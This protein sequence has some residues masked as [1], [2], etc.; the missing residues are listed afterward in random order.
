[1]YSRA[2]NLDASGNLREAAKIAH[3]E[4]RRYEKS[5]PAPWYW[6]FRLLEAEALLGQG[7]VKEANSLLSKP[8]PANL[9]SN[10]IEVRRQYDRAAALYGSGHPH[11]ALSTLEQIR[12]SAT[13]PELQARIDMLSGGLLGFFRKLDE[14][15]LLLNRA[16][17]EATRA[18]TPYWKVGTF[19]N[20]SSCRKWAFRYSEAVEFGLQAAGIAEQ[21]GYRRLGASAHTN[22]GSYYRIL[23]DYDRAL[24]EQRKGIADLAAMGDRNALMIAYGEFGLLYEA[25]QEYRQAIEQ[26]QHAYD[27]ALAMGSNADAARHAVNLS[28]TYIEL[29][30]SE[31]SD[32]S[33]KAEEWN[34]KS[35]QLAGP[36]TASGP[37]QTFNEA[38]IAWNSGRYE[39]GN[40]LSG[41]LLHLNGVPP[42]LLWDVHYY[43][44]RAAASRKQYTD[45]KREYSAAVG[46]VDKARS[47]LSGPTQRITFLSRLIAIHR[48]YIALEVEQGHNLEAIRLAEASRVRVLAERVGGAAQAQSLDASRLTRLATNAKISLISFWLAPQRSYAWLITSA[49]IERF[50]L[51]GIEEIEPVV[52][53]YRDV[54]EHP[55]RDPIATHE[56]NG[57][58]LWD[59]LLA[60]IAPKIPKGSRVIVIPDGPL[61]R[62]NLETLPVPSSPP[63]Y[64]MEDVELAV[65]P[66]LSIAASQPATSDGSGLLAIGAADYAGTDY[67]T[68][69]QADTE[70]RDLE[71]RFPGKVQSYT[72]RQATPAAYRSAQPARFRLIHFAAHAEASNEN[73]LESAVVLSRQGDSNKLYAGD[74]MSIPIH[75]DL[76]T[77]SGCRSAGVR[78]Y[79]GEG[80]IGFAWAFLQSGAH[81]VV[82]GLW[83][84]SDSSTEPLMNDFY[85]GIA[86]NQDP[87]TAMHAAKLALVRE[88][89]QFAKPYYW[90]GF[91]VYVRSASR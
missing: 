32:Q 53:A 52:T 72:G 30:E 57:P 46:L 26:Y 82:A 55:L 36:E 79:A 77:V 54:V 91:Q 11:E 44:A 84:V 56:P 18:N 81:A 6:K 70:I 87:I 75:A 71:E 64:W 12:G 58:K 15:E 35:R 27:L 34:A 59:L 63:H 28:Q 42:A 4:S 76:V 39:D 74:V 86:S 89:P 31:K 3:L 20:L 38:Q 61:H 5:G 48:G 24:Q 25:R 16:L 43:R 78:A 29:G 10:Q 22:L 14:A 88:K 68:L 90:A 8:V 73:P 1:M 33:Q 37:F 50:D 45:A 13:D 83:D 69:Q 80:L 17:E 9:E 7:K 85:G 65:A 21:Y 66:S 19:I 67:K 47:D 60:K 41:E 40:R 62:L 49:G 2:W 51:P 23:G